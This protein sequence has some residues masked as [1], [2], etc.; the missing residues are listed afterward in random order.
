MEIK[1]LGDV[2]T[3]EALQALEAESKTYTGLHVEMEND[4][5]RKF[6]KDKASLIGGI[7]KRLDRARIDKS[8]EYKINVEEEAARIKL[9]LEAANEPFQALIDDYKVLRA[10]QLVEEKA[11]QAAKD[12]AF[13]LPLDHE[14][15]ITMNKMI[16]FEKAEA[17]R[18]AKERDEKIAAEARKQAEIEKEQAEE[19]AELAEKN[20]ILAEAKAKRDA[21]LRY[22]N[23]SNAN[24]S[25]ANLTG[26]DLRYVN[27]TGANLTGADL[28]Y[29]NL[30]GADL[31]RS[32]GNSTQIKTMQTSQYVVTC[33]KDTIA[34][35][36]QQHSVKEWEEFS[37]SQIITMDGVHALEWWNK[38]K[39][40]VITLARE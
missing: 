40:I 31:R 22:A 12:L 4:K 7:L 32:V 28:R 6:V 33:T 27:L 17:A 21:Y 39:D 23:L 34:I 5:E 11:L 8:K 24:L 10:K 14:E 30:T 18:E 20:R 13:Q 37:D 9:R 19:R 3:E 29:V 16:D 1:L 2:T 15:A 25:N 26:A 36:C 35:G 38:Y